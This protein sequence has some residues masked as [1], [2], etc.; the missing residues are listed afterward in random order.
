MEAHCLVDVE[1]FFAATNSCMKKVGQHS[2]LL[3]NQLSFKSVFFEGGVGV[4][5]L[6]LYIHGKTQGPVNRQKKTN[7]K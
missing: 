6:H 7:L 2:V 5:N 3:W 4:T 1:S